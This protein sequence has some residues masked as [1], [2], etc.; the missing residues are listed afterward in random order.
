[1]SSEPDDES[2]H[3]SEEAEAQRRRLLQTMV[4]GMT[5]EDIEAM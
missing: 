4:H 2:D 1:M 3:T 5:D